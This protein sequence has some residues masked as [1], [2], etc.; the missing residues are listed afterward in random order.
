MLGTA[1]V[2]VSGLW[3]S[4]NA[5]PARKSVGLSLSFATEVSIVKHLFTVGVKCPVVALTCRGVT[6]T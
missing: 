5:V 1:A 2:V 6:L 3:T 4:W